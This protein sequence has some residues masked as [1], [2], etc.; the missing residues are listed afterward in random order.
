MS[1]KS[2]TALITSTLALTIW[3]SHTPAYAVNI[4][5]SNGT[6]ISGQL[7]AS[8]VPSGLGNSSISWGTSVTPGG[9]P[10][11]YSFTGRDN[12]T[13]AEDGTPTSLGTFTHNN[14]TITLDSNDLASATLAVSLLGDINKDFTFT[15]NHLETVNTPPA[16]VSCEAGGNSPCPDSVTISNFQ[17]TESID[18]N[19]Q[20]FLLE[21]L[22][23]QQAGIITTNF[24][25]QENQPNSA[26]LIAQ[27]T[28]A[29]TAVPTPALLPGLIGFGMSIARKRKQ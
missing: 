27:L 2:L 19:G 20:T 1:L 15:M 12:F 8:G 29:A 10:S 25:T 24:L 13:L 3:G 9:Q 5:S 11:S 22:G 4:S 21:I 26:E 7:E 17:S 28:P 16:G 23:F 18:I 6:W 14:F